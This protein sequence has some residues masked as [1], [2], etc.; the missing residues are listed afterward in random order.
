MLS[1]YCRK[2][3][4]N[5]WGMVSSY[6]NPERKGRDQQAS[7]ALQDSIVLLGSPTRKIQSRLFSVS[8]LDRVL[9]DKAE[10]CCMQ[11][12]FRC[13]GGIRWKIAERLY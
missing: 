9:I 11:A 4:L 7:D 5:V 6:T 3:V 12:R 13:K 2:I 1:S 10:A 8:H